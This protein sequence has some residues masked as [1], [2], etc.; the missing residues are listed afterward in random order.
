MAI[1][2]ARTVQGTR[3]EFQIFVLVK[4][5]FGDKSAPH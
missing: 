1:W 2:Y 5:A 4:I 3:N